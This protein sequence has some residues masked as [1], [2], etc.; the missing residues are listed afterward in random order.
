MRQILTI[1]KAKIAARVHVSMA[2]P[3]HSVN[4]QLER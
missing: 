1:A 4:A 2:S 3:S